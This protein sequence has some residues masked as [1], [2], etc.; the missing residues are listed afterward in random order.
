M[1]ANQIQVGSGARLWQKAR[2]D[3]SVEQPLGVR[4]SAAYITPRASLPVRVQ[5]PIA[6]HCPDYPKGSGREESNRQR[7]H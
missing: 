5:A 7:S 4:H 6:G 2:P 3:P 1:A